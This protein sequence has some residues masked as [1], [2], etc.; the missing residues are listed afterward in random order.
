MSSLCAETGLAGCYAASG[1][2][3]CAVG[4]IGWPEPEDWGRACS[5]KTLEPIAN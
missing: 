2:G 1:V 5:L 3:A 4:R